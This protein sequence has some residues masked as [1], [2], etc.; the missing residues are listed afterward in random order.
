MY[1]R[2]VRFEGGSIDAITA[3]GEEV[4][5]GLDAI[6][7]GEVGRY[8]PKELVERVSRMEFL[9]DRERGSTAILLYCESEADVREVDRIMDGMSPQREGWGKRVSRDVYE[10]VFDKGIAARRAA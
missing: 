7:R 3:E 2:L 5:A 1:A 10:V 4:K 9:A 6:D 8:F